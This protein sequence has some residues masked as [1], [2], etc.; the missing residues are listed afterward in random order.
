MRSIN[1][2]GEQV[3]DRLAYGSEL[4]G[5]ANPDLG[6]WITDGELIVSDIQAAMHGE[7]DPRSLVERSVRNWQAYGWN[8]ERVAV[9]MGLPSLNEWLAQRG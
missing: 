2:R 8:I 4:I 1:K 6:D 9:E 5:E 7:L 3:A